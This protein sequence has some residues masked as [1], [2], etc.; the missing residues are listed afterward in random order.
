MDLFIVVA[1]PFILSLLLTLP[2]TIPLFTKS[3]QQYLIPVVLLV[4]FGVLVSHYPEIAANGAYQPDPIPWI[5]ELELNFSF[6][7]DGLS[8]LF[9]LVVTGIGAV[10]FFYT[11]YYF[12]EDEAAKQTRFNRWLTAFTGAMLGLVLSGNMVLM[13][14]MWELT[15]I[16]SFML[17]GFYGDKD[18]EARYSA[19]RALVITGGGGLAL[20]GG[21]LILG[22]VAGQTLQSAD[23]PASEAITSEATAPNDVS[24]E[25]AES[26]IEVSTEET[27]TTSTTFRIEDTFTLPFVME[28]SDV[29][30]VDTITDHPW[31]IAV[32][33]L[34]MLGAFTK[35]AQVPFHFWLPGAMTAPTPASAF[36]HSA[37]MVKAGIYLLARL[38]P[39][40]YDHW[41]WINGLVLVGVTTMAVSA[42]FAIK[43]ND[44]KGMLAYATT[45]WLGILVALIGLP[46]FLGFKALAVG[47]LAHAFYKS[48]M[49]LVVG[50]IDH[51]TGTRKLTDLG[52]MWQHMPYNGVVMILSALSMA[53]VPFLFG[54][55]AKE[56]LLD[57]TVSYMATE[58]VLSGLSLWIV[59]GSAALLG[60]TGTILI[61]DVFFGKMRSDVHYHAMRSGAVA[62]PLVLAIGGTLLLPF[63][64]ETLIHDLVAVVTP[65][66]FE[67]HLFPEGGFANPFFQ[68][69][70]LALAIAAIAFPARR[71]FTGDWSLLPFT[72]AQAY[73]AFMNAIDGIAARTVLTQNGRIRYYLVSILSIVTVIFLSSTFQQN[74]LGQTL[75]NLTFERPNVSYIL[76]AM[77]IVLAVA[78][79]ATSIVSKRHLIAALAVSVFGYA[80]AG[81]FVVEHAPDVALVQFLVETLS[82]ILIVIMI[83]RI[84]HKQRKKMADDLWG[85]SPAGVYRDALISIGIGFAV[86][87]F[88]LTAIANRPVRQSTAQWYIDNTEA[89]IGIPDVVAAIVSDFRGM[90]TLIEITVFSVAALG[91]L[92]LLALNRMNEGKG[93]LDA[94]E[95]KLPTQISTSTPFT[96]TVAYFV[97]PVA[98]MLAIVHLLYGGEGPGDG[99]TAGIVAGLAVALGYVVFGYYEIRQRG[100]WRSPVALVS[101][102]L[103][104]ALLNA[105][106]PMLFG[107]PWMYHWAWKDFNF[108]HLHI[109]SSVVFEIAIATTVFGGVNI[110]LEAIAHPRDI[111]VLAGDEAYDPNYG[112]PPAERP[113]DG[114][115]TKQ[116]AGD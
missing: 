59:L 87:I 45:S 95:A 39:I 105:F 23:A 20:L 96:R 81:I 111:E 34:M 35:S 24:A 44:L 68:Y 48:A 72:G 80:V 28:F 22:A 54:F 13:F 86:F 63:A 6:Y 14:I 99:F 106:I 58:T 18:A 89:I 112:E 64:T 19:R 93:D 31:Y 102:G 115:F 114:N 65:K 70:L 90:D 101:F 38:H 25:R 110:I 66:E 67:L 40:M 7:L 107:Q 33:I 61:Y 100:H 85:T 98:M 46:N 51:S 12:S 104:L 8:L 10:I 78:S 109:A 71:I 30:S 37:T 26:D 41:L 92:S 74:L 16:T 62:G 27:S 47:I 82:T 113:L 29:L 116:P 11:G 60:V 108:A 97:Y 83:G 53:G 42:L 15:S 73:A 56:V 76:N 69:S 50:S 21:V 84:S 49:F 2:F 94:E 55:L 52:G 79:I 9:G 57:A 32:A 17:I 5:P 4:M 88:A 36:L 3:L 43:Q 77:L 1:T 75:N 103:L 91:I